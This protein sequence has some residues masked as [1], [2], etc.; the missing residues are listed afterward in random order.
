M[1]F[2]HKWIW[3]IIISKTRCL[4]WIRVMHFIWCEIPVTLLTVEYI[5]EIMTWISNYNHGFMRDEITYHFPNFNGGL[6]KPRLK[7]GHG[8]VFIPHYFAL[9]WL[10]I[11][12]QISILIDKYRCCVSNKKLSWFLIAGKTHLVLSAFRIQWWGVRPC[13]VEASVL[14]DIDSLGSVSI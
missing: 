13:Y 10:L 2:W 9:M 7:L 6:A 4:L 3:F 1:G 5:T 14:G 8:W 12:D 11:H